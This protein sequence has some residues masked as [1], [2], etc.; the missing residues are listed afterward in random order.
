M[1]PTGPAAETACADLDAPD[2]IDL[3]PEDAD[4]DEASKARLK[5]AQ[6]R[7]SVAAKS[8]TTHLR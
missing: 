1:D 6:V 8:T 2:L 5:R 7:L 3:P 4:D